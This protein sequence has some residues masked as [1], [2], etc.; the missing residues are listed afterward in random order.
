MWLL[1]ARRNHTPRKWSN[2]GV[3][4]CNSEEPQIQSKN[5]GARQMK[6][7]TIIT[8]ILIM[9]CSYNVFFSFLFFFAFFFFTRLSFCLIPL[10][11]TLFHIWLSFFFFWIWFWWVS[12]VGF[13]WQCKMGNLSLTIFFLNCLFWIFCLFVSSLTLFTIQFNFV[14]RFTVLLWEFLVM[15]FFDGRK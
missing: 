5:K 10:Y 15:G 2:F 7:V 4:F 3:P 9:I 14:H 1:G 13:Y 11:S 12:S 6:T 8:T